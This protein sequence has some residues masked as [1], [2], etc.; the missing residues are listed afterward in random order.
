MLKLATLIENPGEPLIDTKYH[1]HNELKSIGYNGVVLYPTTALSGISTPDDIN[2]TELKRWIA[3]HFRRVDEQINLALQ[4]NL[5]VY[6]F[7]D[8]LV[9]PTDVVSQDPSNIC[10][11]NRNDTICPASSKAYE[12]SIQALKS[13]ILRWPEITGIVLRFGDSDAPRL[14]FLTGNDIYSPYCPRCSTL[15]K[16]D[17]ISQAIHLAY[18]TVVTHFNKRLIVRAWNVRPNGL[19]DSVELAQ[20]VNDILPGSENDDHLMLSFKFTNTD[21]WRYQSWNKASQLF[22]N[23]PIL[24]ELQCQ[25]EFEGKGSL[26]NWQV[27]LWQSGTPEA[28]SSHAPQGLAQVAPNI[29]FAGILSWVRGGGWGGPFINNEAWID[30]NAY[31]TP[32]L[33]DNPNLDPKTIALDWISNRL[34]IN[35]PQIVD[36]LTEILLASSEIVRKAFYIEDYANLRIDG[37]HPNANWIQDDIFDANELYRVIESLPIESHRNIILEK[38]AAVQQISRYRNSLQNLLVHQPTI[39]A[40]LNSS[41]L[42]AESLIETIQNLID[43]LAAYKEYKLSSDNSLVPHITQRLFLAQSN[44]NRHTQRTSSLPGSPTPFR[45][46]NFWE[47]TQNILSEIQSL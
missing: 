19:H 30:S 4:A 20:R 10:C 44:W 15:T 42:Y 45:E 41:L 26:C 2:S 3:S 40:P 38:R 17:R 5:N 7:Y 39:Y 9:L 32:K 21:F 22:G 25:R 34:N 43:G 14:P 28:P 27:P 6:L 35:D 16:L 13:H 37:W 11:K 47:L 1:D 33:A 46:K 24:Y 12:L 31:A 8:M 23:R 18:D 36:Q 29:N